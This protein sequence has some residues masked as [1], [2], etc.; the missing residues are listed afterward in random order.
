MESFSFS[1]ELPPLYSLVHLIVDPTSVIGNGVTIL[2]PVIGWREQAFSY[3]LEDACVLFG[4]LATLRPERTPRLVELSVQQP[5]DLPIKVGAYST[6]VM[7]EYNAGY[8]E[9]IQATVPV[10]EYYDILHY[11]RRGFDN[12]F[13]TVIQSLPPYALKMLMITE[14]G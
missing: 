11:V 14:T 5:K 8:S 4:H 10:G 1:F 6:Y 3:I 12:K 9:E 13:T 2:G 7:E